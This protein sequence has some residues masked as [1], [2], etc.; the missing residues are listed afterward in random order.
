V[1]TMFKT[2]VV[3]S[4]LPGETADGEKVVIRETQRFVS[5]SERSGLGMP[6]IKQLLHDV[7]NRQEAV[8]EQLGKLQG[9]RIMLEK[10]EKLLI[11]ASQD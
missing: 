9:E 8:G 3:D 1:L 2:K 10:L 11:V 6:D 4:E 7:R 5:I